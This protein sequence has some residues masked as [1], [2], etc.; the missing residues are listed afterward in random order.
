MRATLL[1]SSSLPPISSFLNHCPN[2]TNHHICGNCSV[3]EQIEECSSA[4]STALSSPTQSEANAALSFG[5]HHS[6]SPG[7]PLSSRSLCLLA[8]LALCAS[9]TGHVRAASCAVASLCR[10]CCVA[11][12]VRA[13]SDAAIMTHNAG[14]HRVT[15]VEAAMCLVQTVH[16]LADFLVDWDLVVDALDQLSVATALPSSSSSS[17]ST[18]A[19]L[20][21]SRAIWRFHTYSIFVSDEGLVRLMTS[22]VTQSL[23]SLNLGVAAVQA[24]QMG[25]NSN[26]SSNP[27]A[28]VASF[29]LM[30]VI[31]ITKRNCFRVS[32]IWQMVTSHLRMLGSSK[33]GRD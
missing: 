30:A 3:Y 22:L 33:V 7:L 13:A 24:P 9:L 2:D 1:S 26:S 11:Q 17:S 15:C 4:V 16:C 8:E 29:P 19:N 10:N 12:Q 28:S 20:P 21:L 25:E 6:L 31:E 18:N 23:N 27:H 14:I 5:S 32:S